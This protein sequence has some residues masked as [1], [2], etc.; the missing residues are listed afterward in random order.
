M[1]INDTLFERLRTVDSST[2][3]MIWLDLKRGKDD[4]NFDEYNDE[5]KY[6]LISEEFRSVAGHSMRN[7]LRGPH[8]LAYEAILVGVANRLAPGWFRGSTHKPSDP[9]EEIEAT[10]LTH[11]DERAKEA[12]E[13]LTDQGKTK[14]TGDLEEQAQS[15]YGH[16]TDS[17]QRF[18]LSKNGLGAAIGAGL[19]GGG[20][21]FGLVNGTMIATAGSVV[22]LSFAQQLGTWLI[23]Q[24]FGFWSGV[25]LLGSASLVGGTMLLAPAAAIGALNAIASPSYGKTVPATIRLLAAIELEKQFATMAS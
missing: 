25:W 23:F 5:Q 16:H 9:A 6:M 18:T 17:E 19:I 14:L 7:A 2:L 22:G 15:L 11:L 24:I 8:E 1:P 4:E 21:A 12:W 13:K 10:I 20:G 3:R